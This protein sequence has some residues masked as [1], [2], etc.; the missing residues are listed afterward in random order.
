MARWNLP[1]LACSSRAMGGLWARLDLVKA[2]L[3][4]L[5]F[6]CLVGYW[7]D[8]GL[9]F[10][11]FLLPE[12]CYLVLGR[13]H[14]EVRMRLAERGGGTFAALPGRLVPAGLADELTDA[15]PIEPVLRDLEAGIG[16]FRR[17]RVVFGEPPLPAE[18]EAL[19]AAAGPVP[20][21]VEVA[22]GRPQ[23]PVQA[24][25]VTYAPSEKRVAFEL[26][27][28]PDCRSCAAVEVRAGAT[29]LYA[30]RGA[31]LPADRV[32]RLSVDRAEAGALAASF[33]EA[34]GKLRTMKLALGADAEAEPKVLVI[35]DR[36][37]GRSF[38]EALY[39]AR[40]ATPAE[41]AGLDLLAYELVVVDG[42]PLKEIQGT[43]RQGL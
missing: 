33:R 19:A 9:P 28:G 31:D 10:P 6:L 24:L 36:P 35:T 2:G 40:R 4:L 42:T 18:L 8:A 43:L 13:E 3:V 17:A 29:L 32:L 25:G 30:A 21:A 20:L 38:I 11:A 5:P 16:P 15:A 12:R 27:L 26:L 7:T 1:G 23:A 22:E 39:P 41:A 14:D 37:A 34:S